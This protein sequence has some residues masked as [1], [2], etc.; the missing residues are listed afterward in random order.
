MAVFLAHS[1]SG[2]RFHSTTPPLRFDFEKPAAERA[3]SGASLS[4]NLEAQPARH[5]RREY[6]PLALRRISLAAMHLASGGGI[7]NVTD[8]SALVEMA[9]GYA[10]SRVLCAAARLGVADLLGDDGKNVDQLAVECAADA[11]SLYRLLR[12]FGSFGI[13]AGIKTQVFTLTRLRA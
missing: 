2:V 7:G 6:L 10:R 5:N 13:V 8:H 12:A 9:M 11:G 4:C 1:P 3:N